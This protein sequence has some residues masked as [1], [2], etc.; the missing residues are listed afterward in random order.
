MSQSKAEDT[1][2]TAEAK[3]A[4]AKRG[5]LAWT[6]I[7]CGVLGG[8][9]AIFSIGAAAVMQF[10]ASDFD[11]ALANLVTLGASVV[12]GLFL[13]FLFWCWLLYATRE[14]GGAFMGVFA[15]GLLAP[16]VLV[17]VSILLIRVE[18]F[19]GDM[20]P[21]FRWSW[22]KPHDQQL[23][24]ITTEVKTPEAGDGDGVS[25]QPIGENDFP[26]F[27]GPNRNMVIDHVQLE[28]DWE[29]NPPKEIWRR[30]IGAGWSGF[31]VANGYAVTL[32]QRGENEH[33]TCYEVATGE[34][35]W[36]HSL[37]QRHFHV[38]G[39]L[40]PRSTPTIHNGK[41][42]ALGATGILRCLNGANGEEVWTKNLLNETGAKPET[43]QNE[44]TWGRAGSPLIY[45]DQVIVPAGGPEG[46]PYKSLIS[47]NAETGE[48]KWAKGE[49]QVS[50]AS[51]T[52]GTIA[53]V[54]QILSV[55]Q[56]M[57][58]A[59]DPETGD[60]LWNTEW[61]SNSNADAAS[62]QPTVLEGDRVLLSKGYSQ[63]AVLLQ[64]S[65]KDDQWS[66]EKIW[67]NAAVMR[68]KFTN[69][70]VHEG[71]VFGLS[72]GILECVSLED[73]ERQWK[74][75][76]YGHGQALLVGDHI[77]V[78]DEADG[79]LHVIPASPERPKEVAELRTLNVL[80]D[81][82]LAKAWNTLCFASPYLIVRNDREA[83][84][85]ELPVK[86]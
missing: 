16:F 28:V 74:K 25:L 68:T 11:H 41:V 36:T 12:V 65:K 35:V 78:Q 8:L 38:L 31:A 21:I 86:E 51:P 26:Q 49:Y 42:Y 19:S 58:T 53:G 4:P 66:S 32:E 13:L 14:M 71:Y 3:P 84:C 83:A 5:W 17:G 40:G 10:I 57:V 48:V 44:I 80:H 1:T 47:M 52:V 24:D 46:G 69:A 15:M 77:L 29:A 82:G 43:D 30:D 33:V 55:N 60:V 22:E 34:P 18:G 50:Y 75:G 62:S 27:L 20:M 85:F 81:D 9:L 67:S 76:R 6:L 45:G 70:A 73:G 2:S 39:G 37:P 72:D 79:T 63:G 54:E 61:P 59:H 23:A 56:G 64:L 7:V